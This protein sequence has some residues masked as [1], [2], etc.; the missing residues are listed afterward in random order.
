MGAIRYK[1]SAI[2][3]V[4]TFEGKYRA[5]DLYDKTKSEVAPEE[6]IDLILTDMLLG[7]VDNKN[8]TSFTTTVFGTDNPTTVVI[9]STGYNANLGNVYALNPSKTGQDVT[10][11]IHDSAWQIGESGNQYSILSAILIGP[12]TKATK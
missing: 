12:K 5:G 3:R 10:I 6:E 8:V 1:R 7:V 2:K 4:Y 11:T 9:D